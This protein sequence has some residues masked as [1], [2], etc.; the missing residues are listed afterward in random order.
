MNTLILHLSDIHFKDT[1]DPILNRIPSIVAAVRS[2]AQ[3]VGLC[4]VVVTGDI[5]WAGLE[6]QY[7]VA[8][9]FFLSL[10]NE[11]LSTAS[12]AA[13]QYVIVPGNHDCNFPRHDLARRLLIESIQKDPSL[14][15]DKDPSLIG[16]CVG[17]Q[18]S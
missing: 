8:K 10:K 4:I 7:E 9:G 14:A 1:S 17:V 2:A 12:V 6:S 13:V 15:C 18:D 16:S 11:L 3:D 5:A